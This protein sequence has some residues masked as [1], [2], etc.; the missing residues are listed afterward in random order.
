MTSKSEWRALMRDRLS[1]WTPEDLESAGRKAM[2]ELDRLPEWSR[3]RDPAAS[4]SDPPALGVF[5]SGAGEISTGPALRRALGRGWRMAV[6]AWSSKHNVYWFAWLEEDADLRPGPHNIPEPVSP[7]WVRPNA[8]DLLLVPG[9]AFDMKGGRL[10]RGGGFYDRM[11]ARYTGFRVG[12]ALDLQ[13]IGEA[14]PM[15][16]T[17]Q[18]VDALATDAGVWRFHSPDDGPGREGATT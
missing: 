9:L 18:R 10:G 17:D 12:F 5:L 4:P 1:A 6:P 16:R 15:H 7:R 14:L 8:L 3:A 13:R 2:Q 11:L